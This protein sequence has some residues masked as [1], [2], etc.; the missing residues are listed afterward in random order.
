MMHE[1][2]FVVRALVAIYAGAFLF[3]CAR[4]ALAA[5]AWK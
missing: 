3:A 4:G 2:A 1:L 5:F